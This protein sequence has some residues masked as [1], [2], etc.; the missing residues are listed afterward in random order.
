M[1]RQNCYTCQDIY[2]ENYK[3]GSTKSWIPIWTEKCSDQLTLTSGHIN[4]VKTEVKHWMSSSHA[5]VVSGMFPVPSW[6][7]CLSPA[8]ICYEGILGTKSEVDRRAEQ[9]HRTSSHLHHGLPAHLGCRQNT[10]LRH[11]GQWLT[12]I[13]WVCIIHNLQ[14]SYSLHLVLIIVCHTQNK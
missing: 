10:S 1:K 6:T 5:N 13:W 7:S 2:H 4:V 12:L 11:H 9:H 8:A 3:F 14:I